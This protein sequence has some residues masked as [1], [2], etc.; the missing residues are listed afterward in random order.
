M[1][2]IIEGDRISIALA[3]NVSPLQT[4]EWSVKWSFT[5]GALTTGH[6]RII[7][8][9]T[10]YKCPDDIEDDIDYRSPEGDYNLSIQFDID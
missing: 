10:T 4:K 6:Y 2:L 1:P 9:I 5:Y 3:Y 7:K 8:H